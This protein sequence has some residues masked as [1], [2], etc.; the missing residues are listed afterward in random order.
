MAENYDALLKVKE[1]LFKSKSDT[2]KRNALFKELDDGY[3]N[4]KENIIPILEKIVNNVDEKN[5]DFLSAKDFDCC[6]QVNIVLK[7]SPV[8]DKSVYNFIK[9]ILLVNL[10]NIVVSET[11]IT[12]TLRNNCNPVLTYHSVNFKDISIMNFIDTIIFI[13]NYALDFVDLI[14]E[15]YRVNNKFISKLPINKRLLENIENN[16]SS[17]VLAANT[18]NNKYIQEFLKELPNSSTLLIEDYRDV[19]SDLLDRIV[20]KDSN[21]PKIIKTNNFVGNIFYHIGMWWV[22]REHEKY[23]NMKTKRER[24]QLTIMQLELEKN[25]QNDENIDRQINWYREQEEELAYKITKYETNI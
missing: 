7:Y 6:K 11:Q 2:F 17:F 19:P 16:L 23:N 12:N 14:I 21:I 3:T 25:G 24:F 9:N 1:T 5:K 20:N 22:D 13:G 8:K 15:T 4:I 18:L 10:K